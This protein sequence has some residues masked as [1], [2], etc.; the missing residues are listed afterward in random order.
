MKLI[1]GLGNPGKTYQNT[2]HNLGFIIIDELKNSWKLKDFKLESKLQAEVCEGKIG[3]EKIILAKPNTYM[4]NSGVAVSLLMKYYKVKISDL[5]VIHDDIALPLG[6]IRLAIDSSSG[7]HNG[8]KSIIEHLSSQNFIRLKIGAK[9]PIMGKK[10]VPDYVLDKIPSNY[11]EEI[12][13]NKKRAVS[14][15]DALLQDGLEN[16]MNQFN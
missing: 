1:S 14:A 3:R 13:A 9:T 8:I 4:N 15:V 5:I 2:W 6:K 11:K 10:D 16:A 7:G 12:N